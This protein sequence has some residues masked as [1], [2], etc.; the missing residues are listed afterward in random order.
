[1]VRD[2]WQNLNGAWEFAFDDSNVG[3]DKDWHSGKKKLGRSINVPFPFESKLSG[4]AE[5]GFH[6]WAW[7][8]RQ[9]TVPAAWAGKR[10]LLRFGAVDYR[11]K[12]WVNGQLQGEHEGGNVPFALDVTNA[13][14]GKGP[15]TVT[16]R[17]EDPPTDR[18]IPRGKQYWKPE[19]QGIF[20]TRTSGIWQTVWLEAVGQTWLHSVRVQ[21]GMDGLAR[22]RARL[23]R[24][25]PDTELRVTISRNGKDVARGTGMPVDDRVDV[26]LKVQDPALW[27]VNS[28]NLYDITYEIAKGAQTL[29]KVKS[30]L[31]FRT[32][33]IENGRLAVNRIPHYFK[34]VLDQGYWPDGILTAPSDEALQF[35]IKKMQEMGFNGIRKHQ[36]VEDPRW[37][38]WCDKMG[39]LVSGEMANAFPLEYDER[40]SAAFLKEWMEAMD[41]DYNHPSIVVWAPLNESWGVPN[42]TDQRQIN[43]LR[44]MYTMTKSL[45]PTR[46]VID[47]EGWEHADM[48][49]LFATHNYSPNG[50]ALEVSL[51]GFGT[52]EMSKWRFGRS[53]LIPGFSYNG[54]PFYLSEFG[55]VSYVAPGTSTPKASWGYAGVEPDQDKALGRIRSLYE[56]I[57]RMPFIIGICYT[58]LTDVEQ[59]INGLLT[60]DRKDKF[61]PKEIKK[62]N[63][64]LR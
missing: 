44:T 39:M 16:V 4:I 15:Q 29:D 21:A 46:L 59:E 37:L 34:T 12:V 9:F 3:L 13:L 58:Q 33:S 51:R 55:G 10:I 52:A 54:S 57:A 17:A 60:F 18:N 20:Y 28:P 32:V 14:Q 56:G 2:E 25:Q 38:Y 62:L 6:P 41:R 43:Y 35:D 31:G 8:Q 22:F 24:T 61:D 1:M 30:Y 45:D 47:N 19:S 48:T 40:S 26:A 42:A 27:N 23:S 50:A 53:I 63:D 5:T 64:L 49:D 7:Y 36:K 11:A